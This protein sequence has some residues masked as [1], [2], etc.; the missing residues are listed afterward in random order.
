MLPMFRSLAAR[1]PRAVPMLVLAAA[2]ALFAGCS[3]KKDAQPALLA[4]VGGKEIRADYYEDRLKRIEENEL[5]KGPDGQVLDMAQMEG[6]KEFL[7]T[8]INKTVMEVKGQELGYATDPRIAEARSSLLAYQAGLAMYRHAVGDPGDQL[9]NEEVDAIYALL[10]KQRKISYLITNF[11]ADANA[12]REMAMGG[13]DW[14]DV[15]RKFHAGEIPA[16]GKMVL[17]IPYG[18]FDANFEDAVFKTP[19]GEIAPVISTEYGYWVVR[20]D[21]EKELQKPSRD[22]ALAK[23]LDLARNRKIARLKKAFEDE[24][25]TKYKLDIREDAL[26]KVYEGLPEREFILDPATDQPVPQSELKP[27][28]VVPADLDLP[29]YSYEIDG[30]VRS[31]TIGDYKIKYDRMNTFQRPKKEQFLGGLRGHIVSELDRALMDAEAKA[32]GFYEDPEVVTLVD[33][34]VNEMIVT[35]MYGDLVV[36]D[37]R[38]T[39]EELSAFWAD[40]AAEYATPETRVGH[41][42]IAADEAQAGAALAAAEAGAKWETLI[43]RFDTDKTN[44]AQGGRIEA[45]G[46]SGGPIKD[47]IFGLEVGALS[48]P[49][50]VGDGRFAVV[51]LDEIRPAAP[52]TMEASAAA[53]GQRIKTQRKEDMFNSLLAK[54][55]QEVGVVRHDENL[56]AV[57][58]WKELTHVEA[59]GPAVPRN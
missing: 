14:D 26:W 27:L 45:T 17:F 55:S 30:T 58:S 4:V 7:T 18:R 44:T 29:F 42:V 37:D 24:V 3:G 12:A 9:S 35:A 47:A 33:T 49:V 22:D 5:P 1:T 56:S 54:W 52:S 8:L 6:K 11:E 50:A 59:P 39:P 48:V 51:R 23:I 32:R 38:V 2:A 19:I 53:I 34:K 20:I 57:K 31:F 36:V 43:Q 46:L 40:H 10:G 13:A 25:H 15:V 28:N 41:V 21:G 16:D